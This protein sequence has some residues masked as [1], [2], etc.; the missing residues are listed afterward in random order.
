MAPGEECVLHE[1]WMVALFTGKLG[2][3]VET[4]RL[5]ERARGRANQRGIHTPESRGLHGS[6]AVGCLGRLLQHARQRLQ[7]LP[8]TSCRIR[9]LVQ[10]L[11]FPLHN[12]VATKY[13]STEL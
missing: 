6:S 3:P 9:L 2:K 13:F 5:A 12:E 1:K 7:D 11:A 10:P 4:E 8:L